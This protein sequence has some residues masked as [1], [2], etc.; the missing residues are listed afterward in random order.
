MARDRHGGA[1][2]GPK[3]A[4]Q[5]AAVLVAAVFLL[6]GVLGFVPG[7]TAGY[8]DMTFAG[9]TSGAKLFGLF[10][11]SILHNL[12]HLLFGLVGLVLARNVAGS[13]LFL[14]GG[15]AI[16][17]V[18]WLY[19]FAIDFSAEHSVVNFIPLNGP[20]NWLHLGLGFGMLAM[21]LLLS[22]GVGTGEPLDSPPDRP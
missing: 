22:H 9:H 16:Y 6:V 15:G 1:P 13:R 14:G 21:G 20:D 19:G 7:V 4:V 12:L 18:L 10:Q 17:L 2:A 5:G 11:V 3:P 8:D